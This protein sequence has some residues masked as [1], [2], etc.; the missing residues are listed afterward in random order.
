MFTRDERPQVTHDPRGFAYAGQW[1]FDL[2]EE[3]DPHTAMESAK[4]WAAYSLW[5]TETK[6]A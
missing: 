6:F 2:I 1:T 4:A 5:L 3:D